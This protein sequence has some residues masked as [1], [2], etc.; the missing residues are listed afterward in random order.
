MPPAVGVHAV[1]EKLL[2]R[3]ARGTAV[4]LESCIH[5]DQ[6]NILVSDL[7]DRGGIAFQEHVP[8]VRA[9]RIIGGLAVDLSELGGPPDGVGCHQD[10]VDLSTAQ[11]LHEVS[12]VRFVL[13]EGNTGEGGGRL[14]PDVDRRVVD[15]KLDHDYVWSVSKDVVLES[16]SGVDGGI[17]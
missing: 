10:G 12:Q 7:A 4:A 2:D 5:V 3:A 13:L 15:A 14:S 16:S 17:A 6:R 9:G 11:L 8:A 1:Q